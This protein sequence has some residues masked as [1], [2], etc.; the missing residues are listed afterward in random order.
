MGRFVA[1]NP[2]YSIDKIEIHTYLD[3]KDLSGLWL[4]EKLR[5]EC[6]EIIP[7]PAGGN[8]RLWGYR[9]KVSITVPTKKCFEILMWSGLEEYKIT[10]VEL[11]KDVFYK[12]EEEAMSESYRLMRLLRKKYTTKT[13]I[14]DYSDSY[15]STKSAYGNGLFSDKTLYLGNNNLKFVLYARISKINSIPCLHSEWRVRGSRNIKDRLG[16]KSFGDCYFLD[17]NNEYENLT[18]Q[19]IVSE[20]IVTEKLGKY[21]LGWGRMK[22]LTKRQN[23]KVDILA[24]MIL[25]NAKKGSEGKCTPAQLTEWLKEL[26]IKIK[27][28]TGRR[29]DWHKRAM[30]IQSNSMFSRR[31]AL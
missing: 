19:Y 13:E 2:V 28:Q 10:Y 9:S 30:K 21:F 7:L 20:E 17:L 31:V 16:I 23:I 6:R 29:T 25:N 5:K 11:A 26:K 14:L 4:I 27:D 8:A 3:L 15:N 24:I 12:T 22:N 1:M 18:D